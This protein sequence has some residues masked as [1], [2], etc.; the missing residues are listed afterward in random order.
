MPRITLDQSIKK[1]LILA[2]NLVNEIAKA[3]SNEAETRKRIDHILEKL[4]GYD[5]FKHITQEYAIHGSGDSVYCDI[6]IKTRQDEISKPDIIIEVKRVNVDLLPK[7][8]RQAASYAI[9]I[10]CEWILLTNSK[11]WKLYH[12]TFGK[13]P[14][15]KLIEEW[16]LLNDDLYVLANKFELVGYKNVKKQG[17]TLLWEKRNVLNTENILR[18]LLSEEAIKLYRRRIKRIT[19]INVPPED[20]VGSIRYLLN[21]SAVAEMDKLK[22]SLPSKKQH[23]LR[24]PASVNECQPD[25]KIP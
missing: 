10:G 5:T 4:M 13:P 12:I 23:K 15:T 8:V 25:S 16:N 14:Q 3:D 20:I 7:H 2:R 18:A 17:L 24:A 9:D 21:E 11:D 22:I 19:D 6:A 1:T